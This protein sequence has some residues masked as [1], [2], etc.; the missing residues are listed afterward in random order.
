MDLLREYMLAYDDLLGEFDPVAGDPD[1][2]DDVMWLFPKGSE[3]ER[4]G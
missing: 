1:D 4:T 3:D 2:L